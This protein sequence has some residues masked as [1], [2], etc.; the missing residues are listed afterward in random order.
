MKRKTLP[1]KWLVPSNE[2]PPARGYAILVDGETGERFLI[3]VKHLACPD[4]R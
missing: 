3:D 1:K 4:S 2:P